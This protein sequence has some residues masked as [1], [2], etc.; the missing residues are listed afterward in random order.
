M[1]IAIGQVDLD[2]RKYPN[3]T[4]WKKLVMSYSEATQ[5]RLH[6]I[7]FNVE[8]FSLIL[9]SS[10]V[11]FL[12]PHPSAPNCLTPPSLFSS[13]FFFPL[14]LSP[15]L[16]PCIPY[17]LPPYLPPV[18]FSLSLF[19]SLTD[20][21]PHYHRTSLPLFRAISRLSLKDLTCGVSLFQLAQPW[22]SKISNKT[23]V[24]DVELLS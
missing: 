15:S 18:S 22:F 17:S 8:F 4:Q 20:S 11:S 5:Q 23:Q 9:V 19:P 21:L 1:L 24:L 13:L 7:Y 6:F 14:S 12:F 2:A 10:F 16:P 3:I